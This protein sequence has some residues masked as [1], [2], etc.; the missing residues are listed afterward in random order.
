MTPDID[1]EE[2]LTAAEGMS[3]RFAD[4][5]MPMPAEMPAI[6]AATVLI[7]A[8]VMKSDCPCDACS[9]IRALSAT[10]DDLT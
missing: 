8:D 5:G 6:M 2:L 7:F 4:I 3:G 1:P 9:R 10:L